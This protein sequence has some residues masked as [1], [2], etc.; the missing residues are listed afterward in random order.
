MNAKGAHAGPPSNP[1]HPPGRVRNSDIALAARSDASILLTGNPETAR[2]LAY[3][4][5]LASGWRYGAFTVIDCASGDPAL[6]QTLV[7]ALVDDRPWQP[8]VVL[9]RLVQAG[10][11][12]LQ[13]INALPLP[14]QRRLAACLS[15]QLAWAAAGRSRRRV[16][17]S[18]SEPLLDRVLAGTFDDSL[19]YRLNVMHFFVPSAG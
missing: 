7:D 2:R 11:V 9:L 5:H 18:T 16:I 15:D 14:I 19:Y 12:L 17:A 13:E 10:T 8:G 6:E 3:R 4:L 1:G